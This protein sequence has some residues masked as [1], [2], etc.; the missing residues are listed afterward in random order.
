MQ[1]KLGIFELT[2]QGTIFLDEVGSTGLIIQTK[3]LRVS[4][5]KEIF[6]LGGNIPLDVDKCGIETT[7]LDVEQM[8]KTG[9]IWTGLVLSAEYFPHSSSTTQGEKGKHTGTGE[10]FSKKI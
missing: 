5:N 7:N 8:V 10:T 6:R 9:K 2:S 3:L 4:Q 1:R